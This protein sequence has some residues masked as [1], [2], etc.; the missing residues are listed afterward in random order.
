[1]STLGI[2]GSQVRTEYPR[3]LSIQDSGALGSGIQGSQD[4][5]Y[6]RQWYTGLPACAFRDPRYILSILGY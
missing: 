1:M 5:K 3:I 2:K 6:S 4:T